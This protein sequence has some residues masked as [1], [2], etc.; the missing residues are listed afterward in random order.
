MLMD[1]MLTQVGMQ[2]QKTIYSS[3]FGQKEFVGKQGHL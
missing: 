1:K 2:S 3:L